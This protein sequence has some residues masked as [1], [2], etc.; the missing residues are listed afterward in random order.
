M[1]T[2][3]QCSM[4]EI[5]GVHDIEGAHLVNGKGWVIATEKI[6]HDPNDQGGRDYR[7]LSHG[8]T[9][10]SR[11]NNAYG[12]SEG[13]TIPTPDKYPDY[14]QRAQN[15]VR[16][17]SGCSRWGIS[18]EVNLS[19]ERPSG[20]PISPEQYAECYSLCRAK[21]L[22]LPGHEHDL[23]ITAA[24]GPWN[25]ETGDWIDYFIRMLSYAE[26]HGGV[27][28]IAAHTYC[29]GADPALV[30]SDQKM[31]APYDN[32]YYHFRAYRDFMNAIPQSLRHVPVFITE[33]NQDDAW[34]DV[35]SGWVQNAYK[36]I[37]DWNKNNQQKIHCLVLYRY[38]NY[39]K[40][41]IEGKQGVID[42][43]IA[44]Q[45]HGYAAGGKMI[46]E[47]G[48]EGEFYY[49]DDPYDGIP[50]ASELECPVGWKPDWVV[51][52]GPGINHRPEFKPKVK[53]QPEVFEGQKAVGIHTSDSSHDG[54]LYRQFQVTPGAKIRASVQAMGKGEGGHGM[55]VGID[56]AGG[57]DFKTLDGN[58]WGEWWSTDVPDWI[59][60]AWTSISKEVVANSSTI[61]VFLRTTAR[62]AN[63]NTGHFDNFLL[64]SDIDGPIDPPTE[65]PSD[66]GLLEQI[67]DI[68]TDLESAMVRLDAL[69]STIVN[70]AVSALIL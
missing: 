47:D 11:L 54:V 8:A 60:G 1:K 6:G 49:A 23:V 26:S 41:F 62:I 16:N 14:A 33:T 53:P 57:T 7:P 19:R 65:P 45:V 30:F 55:V 18:N 61:T 24:I 28:A 63:S 17:S 56:P 59:E 27:S 64:E 36:E 29:H 66:G 39:D 44:A 69:Q 38:P 50:N 34:V 32:R 51:S 4:S 20:L 58:Y 9:V 40:Y 46:F 67:E 21:I 68:K 12:T 70:G 31:D 22:E 42:D 37:D 5:Y 10:I 25:I 3:G 43:L 35:N 2:H 52:T 48:F 15:F 13:G